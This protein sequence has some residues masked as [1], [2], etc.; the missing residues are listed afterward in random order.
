M[1]ISDS[2]HSVNN[3]KVYTITYKDNDET[4][5]SSFAYVCNHTYC[6]NMSGYNNADKVTDDLDFIIKTIQPDYKQ[7]KD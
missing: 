1:D 4:K 2:T 3:I 6:I 5:Y 7:G